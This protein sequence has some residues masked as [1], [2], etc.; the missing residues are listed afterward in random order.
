METAVIT[1]EEIERTSAQTISELLR[2]TPGLF[3]RAEDAPGVSAWRSKIR[4]LDFNSGY[5]LILIDG[6]RVKGEGM[7]EYGYGSNQIPLEMIERIEV[8][9]GAGSSLYGSDALAGVVNII[10]KSISQKPAY[11]VHAAYGTHDTKIGSLY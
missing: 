11:G 4:G 5:G 10:T 2:Y 6:Q 8:V 7:G 3:I 1:K 9:K